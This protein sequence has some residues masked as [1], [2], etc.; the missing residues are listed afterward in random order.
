MEGSEGI[1]SLSGSVRLLGTFTCLV[2][3]TDRD[4]V[5]LVLATVTDTDISLFFYFMDWLQSYPKVKYFLLNPDAI[6]QKKRG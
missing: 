5:L 1:P 3:C 6:D 4:P 2:V